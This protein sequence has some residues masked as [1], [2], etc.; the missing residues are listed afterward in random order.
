MKGG[1]TKTFENSSVISHDFLLRTFNS[2]S[3]A[4]HYRSLMTQ[5]T[6]IYLRSP[7]N[8]KYLCITNDEV[9][10]IEEKKDESGKDFGK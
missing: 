8:Q 3:L 6:E 10:L 5:T 9:K 4:I 2:I 1:D 7:K